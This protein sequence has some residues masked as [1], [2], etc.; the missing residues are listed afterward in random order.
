MA[1]QTKTPLTVYDD[2]TAADRIAPNTGQR[3]GDGI[4]NDLERTQI[5]RP[6]LPGHGTEKSQSRRQDR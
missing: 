3:I 5:L 2:R 4:S 1:K 6:D